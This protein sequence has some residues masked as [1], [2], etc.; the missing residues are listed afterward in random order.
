M[1]RVIAETILVCWLVLACYQWAH[2]QG[3]V[4]YAIEQA[5]FMAETSAAIDRLTAQAEDLT[6][7]MNNFWRAWRHTT[8]QRRWNRVLVHDKAGQ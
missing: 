5:R 6:T 2:Y 8:W 1:R 4:T 3:R 7:G